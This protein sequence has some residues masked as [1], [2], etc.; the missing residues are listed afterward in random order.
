[1]LTVL[2]IYPCT[3]QLF[4]RPTHQEFRGS[5]RAHCVAYLSEV[6]KFLVIQA[7]LA[8]RPA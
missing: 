2:L 3:R 6:L 1:M 4:T 5:P 8:D 7:V